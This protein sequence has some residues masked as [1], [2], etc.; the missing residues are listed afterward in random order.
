ML[1]N[2]DVIADVQAQ[3]GAV[4]GRFCGEEGIENLGLNL[5]GNARAIVL[6]LL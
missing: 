3:P 4:S 6:Y 2:D 5:L 1:V